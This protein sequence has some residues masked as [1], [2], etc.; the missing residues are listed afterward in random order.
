MGKSVASVRI[1]CRIFGS[2]AE[3]KEKTNYGS[4]K[5]GVYCLVFVKQDISVRLEASS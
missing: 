2:I 1:N 5:N 4:V 3:T